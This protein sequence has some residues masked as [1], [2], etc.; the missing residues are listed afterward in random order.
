MYFICKNMP[1]ISCF[2]A[3]YAN[4]VKVDQDI[5]F[6]QIVFKHWEQSSLHDYTY[7]FVD[8]LSL[9]NVERRLSKRSWKANNNLPSVTGVRFILRLSH[10]HIMATILF[11]PRLLFIKAYL[12]IMHV[13][14]GTICHFADAFIHNGM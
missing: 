6:K 12:L 3:K 1:E 10:V 8:F 7:W 13:Q 2:F 14:D 9:R 11:H 4:N 5:I